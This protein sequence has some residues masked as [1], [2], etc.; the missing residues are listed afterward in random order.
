M[1]GLPDVVITRFGDNDEN[2]CVKTAPVSASGQMSADDPHSRIHQGVMFHASGIVASLANTSSYDVILTTAAGDFPHLTFS[3]CLDGSADIEI[4]EAPSFTGGTAIAAINN[5]LG[6]P[7]YT[8]SVVHS[9]TVSDPGASLLAIHLPGDAGGGS[10]T[11]RGGIGGSFEG[12]LILEESTSYL[13]R[14]TNRSG[15]AARGG[16]ELMFYSCG[17]LL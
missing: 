14:L 16:I 9:P 6:L 10:G 7:N 12:E 8:G 4:F 1:N 17:S 2:V 15:A 13:L 3:A 5:N 11:A